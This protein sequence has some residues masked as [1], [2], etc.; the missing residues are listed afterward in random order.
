MGPTLARKLAEWAP[1]VRSPF[2]EQARHLPGLLVAEAV[3]SGRPGRRR[4]G[5][6]AGKGGKRRAT[7]RSLK[8]GN[9]A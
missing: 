1:V 3:G 2:E 7:S 6:V 9:E 5:V 8:C 4:G